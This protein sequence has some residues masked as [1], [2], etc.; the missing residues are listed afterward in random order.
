[1]NIQIYYGSQTGNS[2]ELAQRI[3]F[4]FRL[5]TKETVTL[6]PISTFNFEKEPKPDDFFIFCVSTTGQGGLKF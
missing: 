3:E 1:M 2:F 5:E 6:C 4:M